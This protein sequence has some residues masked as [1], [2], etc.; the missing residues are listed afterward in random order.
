MGR[1]SQRTPWFYPPPPVE[2]RKLG[3]IKDDMEYSE[4][5]FHYTYATQWDEVHFLEFRLLHRLNIFHLQ[6][7]LAKLK[8]R[9]WD[10]LKVSDTELTEI[11]TAL[12]SYSKA[13]FVHATNASSSRVL[14]VG[15]I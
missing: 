4:K 2:E 3:I 12:H 8:G 14:C 1:H 11:G 6:N 7:K 13:V 15:T 5:L 10:T 9:Y